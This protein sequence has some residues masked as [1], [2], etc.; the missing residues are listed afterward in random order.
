MPNGDLL[1]GHLIN[2]T[3]GDTRRRTEV[4]LGVAYGSDLS[5]VDRVIKDVLKN[6]S[7]VIAFPEPLVLFQGF[8]E[9]AISIKLFFW[10]GHF[11]E[12]LQAKSQVIMAIDAAFRENHITI[13]FP[14]RDVHVKDVRPDSARSE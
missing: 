9:S 7:R 5:K 1:S 6:E 2:W 3:G 8:G 12:R 13:P 14:Q 4:D 11:R 10:V